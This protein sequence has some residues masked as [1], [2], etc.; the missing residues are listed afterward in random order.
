MPVREGR[1]NDYRQ[2]QRRVDQAAADFRGFEAAELYPPTSGEQNTWSVV[3]RFATIEQLATWLDSEERRELLDEGE[4]LF[5]EE[6]KQEILAGE[7]PPPDAV[8]AVV[9]HDIKPGHEREFAQWQHKV[10]KVQEKT[11]GFMGLELFDP[12]PGVQDKWV[13]VFRYDSREHLDEWLESET[14]AKLLEEGKRYFAGYDVR[15]ISSAFSGW[16]RFN[17]EAEAGVPPNWKQAMTVLLA[18]YP[19]V[20]VLNLT[21]GHQLDLVRLPG[22]LSLFIG[23]ALS[24]SILTWL[25]MP[26]VNRIFAFWLVPGRMRK[27]VT[28]LL[29]VVAV[30]ACYALFLAAFAWVTA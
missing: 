9:S 8:T 21:V 25:L 22:Y 17:G 18:L 14:R 11:P 19:T 7:A 3:F 26:L 4:D 24:V 6:P 30:V 1:E 29:G 12:V 15:K 28:N 27:V 10:R 23:N 16:F 13:A 2:W 5:E 20:M